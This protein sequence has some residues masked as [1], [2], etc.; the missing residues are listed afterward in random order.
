VID[1]LR[2][3]GHEYGGHQGMEYV[4]VGVIGGDVLIFVL[5]LNGRRAGSSSPQMTWM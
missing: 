5:K 2:D 3:N 1:Y 4:D